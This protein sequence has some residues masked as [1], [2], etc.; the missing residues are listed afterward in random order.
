MYDK[1]TNNEIKF[2][3]ICSMITKVLLSKILYKS[4]NFGFGKIMY[5]KVYRITFYRQLKT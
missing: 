5:K 3:T 2:Q 4:F 1:I